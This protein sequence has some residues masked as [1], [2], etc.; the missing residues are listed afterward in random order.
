MQDALFRY[1]VY[2][3]TPVTLDSLSEELQKDIND[4][5][6]YII[7]IGGDGT[8]NRIIQKIA[9]KDIKLFLIPAGTANDLCNNHM[10][11]GPVAHLVNIFKYNMASSIDLIKINEIYMATNGGLG[12]PNAV[13]ERINRYRGTVPGFKRLMRFLGG[14]IYTLMLGLELFMERLR[15]HEFEIT[16]ADMPIN[17]THFRASVILIN[18]QAVLGNSFRVAPETRNDDGRFNVTIFTH[19]NR[20]MFLKSVIMLRLGKIPKADPHF[21]AFETTGLEISSCD[22][23]K[24]I[25]FGD[26]EQLVKDT[27]FRIRIC[28]RCLR[29]ISGDKIT[30]DQLNA[31]ISLDS[32]NSI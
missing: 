31:P 25:F 12:L 27:H 6:Q 30:P 16:C 9:R 11:H 14:E 28:H 17:K 1:D 15:P 4:S 13:T 32:I 2:F 22:D 3:K 24:H 10:I 5:V 7:G 18:N 21:T 20:L 8:A 23:T 26:G 29:L 19:P